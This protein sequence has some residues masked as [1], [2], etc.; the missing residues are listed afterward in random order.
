MQFKPSNS[1]VISFASDFGFSV[2]FFSIKFM[3]EPSKFKNF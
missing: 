3:T 2:C 1:V